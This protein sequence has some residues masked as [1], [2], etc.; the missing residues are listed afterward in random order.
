LTT[1]SAFGSGTNENL[2]LIDGVNVT[3]PCSGIARSEPVVDFIRE[4]QVRAI[5]VSAEFGNM[6]GAVINVVTKQGSERFQYDASYYGQ[7]SDLTSQPVTLR[8]LG[9]DEQYSGYGRAKYQDF[10]SSFG[11][12]A[13]RNRLWFFGGYQRLRDNDSQPGTDPELP[14]TYEM[15]KVFAK[16]TWRLGPR[17]QLVQ[18]FH[19]EIGIDPDRPTIVTPF[20]AT[21]RTHITAPAMTFGNLAHMMS[22]STLW[23]VHVARFASTRLGD[24]ST[25]DLATPS[26]FDRVTGVTTGAPP[27]IGSVEIFRTTARGTL[28][29]YRVL[30][31]P[32]GLGSEC[33]YPPDSPDLPDPPH[34][35][36][37]PDLPHQPHPPHPPAPPHPP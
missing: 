2:F 34:L 29:H 19:D 36:D 10:T 13:I 35:P 37:P 11:G 6:Q 7:T 28:T 3:C 20:E 23:D 14:R 31:N 1:F 8:Y 30:T 5:G 33:P 4:I 24:P 26:R 9:S 18:S 25:G 16:L 21:A 27:R 32:V 22:A 15:Q 17:W 12:P